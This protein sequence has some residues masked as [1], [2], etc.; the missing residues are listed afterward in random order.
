MCNFGNYCLIPTTNNTII[1]PPKGQEKLAVQKNAAKQ[2][3]LKAEAEQAAKLAAQKTA[4]QIAAQ[5]AMQKASTQAKQGTEKGIAQ[6]GQD[7]LS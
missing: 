7:I 5:Q 1:V 2:E 3:A 4:Q 6:L